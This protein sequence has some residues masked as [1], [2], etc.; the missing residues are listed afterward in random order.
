MSRASVV[1]GATFVVVCAAVVSW[2]WLSSSDPAVEHDDAPSAVANTVP[3]DDDANV[4]DRAER[5]DALAKAVETA[6]P[7]RVDVPAEAEPRSAATTRAI[8]RG[9]IVLA[10]GQPAATADVRLHGWEA[11]SERVIRH[12]KPV[13]WKDP[14]PELD[15][16]G[17]FRFEFE[18]PAAYQ[19]ALDVR[20]NGHSALSWRWVELAAGSDTDVGVVTLNRGCVVEGDV[21]DA[22]GRP[23]SFPVRI[24]LEINAPSFGSAGAPRDSFA[25]VDA[26]TGSFRIDDANP[27]PARVCALGND[28]STFGEARVDVTR[29]AVTRCRIVYAGPDLQRAIALSARCEKLH[30]FGLQDPR[31]VVLSG[32]PNGPLDGS[33]AEGGTSPIGGW[34]SFRWIDLPVGRYSLSIDDPRFLPW[35]KSEVRTGEVVR[36]ALVG[37]CSVALTVIDPTTRQ[38]V[39]PSRIRLRYLAATFAPNEFVLEDGADDHVD[40]VYGGIVP[41]GK[42]MLIVEADG[43]APAE[44][45]LGK[46]EPRTTIARSVELARGATLRGRVIAQGSTQGRGGVTVRLRSGRPPEPKAFFLPQQLDERSRD[47]VTDADGGFAFDGLMAGPYVLWA[48]RNASLAITKVPI[49]LRA[50]ESVTHDLVIPMS[51]SLRA[52]IAWRAE[53]PPKGV[54]VAVR[55][56]RADDRREPTAFELFE[57]FGDA[58]KPIVAEVADDGSFAIESVPIGVV[59]L[60]LSMPTPIL[61]F[62]AGSLLGNPQVLALGNVTIEADR[63]TTAEF[64][65][66]AQHPGFARVRIVTNENEVAGLEVVA[67]ARVDAT[68]SEARATGSLD[69]NGDVVL[70][71]FLPGPYELLVKHANDAWISMI[72]AGVTIRA[73]EVTTARHEIALHRGAVALYDA[74]GHPLAHRSF[75]FERLGVRSA[76]WTTDAAG[77]VELLFPSFSGSIVDAASR[78]TNPSASVGVPITWPPASGELRIVWPSR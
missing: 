62:G 14:T 13:G 7:Q 57:S 55:V 11:N 72:E 15:A 74:E 77:R 23:V 50:G 41:D 12:G 40:G 16:N 46:L 73:A 48:E 76:R 29:D 45:E 58:P 24:R 37:S 2:L 22:K 38:P 20:A 32:H 61:R 25:M 43:F 71:P 28:G 33:A 67:R 17:S 63:E 30:V 10:D 42:M 35:T 27:G 8:V 36:A 69:A 19:F 70:G 1:L 18:P 5:T 54:R 34:G 26:T 59:E 6:V 44:V 68:T 39:K 9:R 31:S 66:G 4:P 78:A 53:L 60:W 51:G 52:R 65:L 49:D 47:A 75:A 64:D 3:P 56:P 21:V